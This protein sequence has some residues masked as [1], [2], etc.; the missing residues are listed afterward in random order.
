MPRSLTPAALALAL[1]GCVHSYD[2]PTL[3]E[4]PGP[5]TAPTVIHD[6]RVFTATSADALEHQDVTLLAGR[7]VSLAPTA[8]VPPGALV[9]EGGG[10]TLLPG[11]VDLHVHLDLS[12]SASWSPAWPAPDH[13]GQ[14]LL[15]SGVTTALDVG[16]DLGDLSDIARRQRDGSWLGPRMFFSGKVVTVK[17]S[18]PVSWIRLAFGWP[19]GGIAAGKAAEEISTVAEGEK[20]IDDRVAKGAFQL[21]LAVAQVPL[22]TPVMTKELLEPLV[23][24]AHAKGLKVG[25][26]VD[27]AEHALLAARGGADLLLHG[28]HLGGLTL[29]QAQELAALKVRVAPTLDVWDRIEAVRDFRYQPTAVEQ[30]L[31]PKEMLHEYSPEVVKQ[32]KLDPKLLAWIDA[33][34]ASHDQR[35]EAVRMLRD[36]GVE[37]V[38][39]ADDN[40]SAACW[41]GGG[42]L[43]ELRLLSE[44]G[45]ANAEVLKAA[46]VNG[47]RYLDP[48]PDFGT[49]EAGKRAD[50]VLVDGDPLTDITA[51]SR[52]A[53]V[54]QGGVR[55]IRK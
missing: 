19:L 32:Q 54:F 38:V 28:V 41:A 43:D 52:I 13:A 17:D 7:I 18:Y 20:L 35:L 10:K 46:T 36:A 2:F 23:K 14:A 49:V 31:F 37:L 9:V 48:H 51:T 26:H 12:A 29:A 24:A 3:V 39:G 47:A 42:Y 22:D 11:Y 55:M 15:Y 8:A 1:A 53:E 25:V 5:V 30:H 27:T 44:A 40:G 16:G 33:L 21:K 34:K 6:V 50:L 45:I 4:R